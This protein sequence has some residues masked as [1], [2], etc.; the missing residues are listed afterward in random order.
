MSA[1]VLFVQ[2]SKPR[3]HTATCASKEHLNNCVTVIGYK[4]HQHEVHLPAR[5]NVPARTETRRTQTVIIAFGMFQSTYKPDARSYNVQ[6]E[7]LDSILKYGK[8][9][10]GEW[11]LNGKRLPGGVN[12]PALP[13]PDDGLPGLTDQEIAEPLFAEV[14]RVVEITDGAPTQ[15][16]NKTNYRQ[17]AIWKSKKPQL[18]RKGVKLITMHGK[19]V[20]DGASNMPPIALAQAAAQGI[21]I[22]E[23][24]RAAVL[25][26]AQ[27]RPTP[28]THKSGIAGYWKADMILYGHYET[29]LFTSSRVGDAQ[30]FKGS[31][32]VHM[33]VGV[34][35]PDE[36]SGL[37]DG[38]LKV[39]SYFCG[40][41]DCSGPGFLDSRNCVMADVFG[42]P[43]QVLVKAVDST[44]LPSQ[45]L[46]LE[47]FALKLQRDT[48]VAARVAADEVDIEGAVWL[49]VLNGPARKLH[50]AE[51]HAGQE[52]AAGWLVVSAHWFSLKE[53]KENG[54]RGYVILKEE[55]VLNVNSLIRKIDISFQTKLPRRA[56]T[57]TSSTAS[58]D[59]KT[60]HL[61]LPDVWENLN[62]FL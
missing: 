8:A 2:L 25:Y 52:F 11:F 61:L 44:G 18:T 19:G 51:M 57:S 55:V 21:F 23:G 59:A 41:A 17:T 1:V 48:I 24:S 38:P 33:S 27:A 14:L 43:S 39:S 49:A 42:K 22:A 34:P 31:S 35:W 15:F 56:R 36:T 9:I 45:T 40:C 29:T 53:V 58:F 28:Q 46:E 26:L 12:R 3:K 32:T 50:E 4:P 13:M 10:H 20:C 47:A 54:S 16:D 5:R 60:I 37:R 62:D 30:P 7:D 6:A